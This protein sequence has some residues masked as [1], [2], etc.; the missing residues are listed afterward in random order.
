MTQYFDSVCDDVPTARGSHRIMVFYRSW[1]SI[2]QAF[3]SQFLAEHAQSPLRFTPPSFTVFRRVLHESFANVTRPRKGSQPTCTVC[4]AIQTE[5]ERC[6]ARNRAE[7]LAQSHAHTQQ[8]QQ[9]RRDTQTELDSELATGKALAIRFDHMAPV[10]V[11]HYRLTPK[12]S[13]LSFCF[14]WS[15][16]QSLVLVLYAGADEKTSC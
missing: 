3:V 2:H 1:P 6:D 5:L 9:Q 11:P 10:Q 12:V 16:I 8:H 4:V 13:A 14:G 7:I 15:L